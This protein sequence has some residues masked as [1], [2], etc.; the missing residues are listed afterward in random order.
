MVICFLHY[1]DRDMVI[2]ETRSLAEVWV[3]C[4]KVMFF[5]EYT[6][7]VQRQRNS[8]LSAN[9]RLQELGL[10]YYLLF[11]A[12][13]CVVAA[14]TMHFFATPEE[15]WHWIENPD[16]RTAHLMRPKQ[17]ESSSVWENRGGR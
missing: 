2:K 17:L 3:D 1:C 14:G 9:Q 16:G 12:K 10:A 15:A 6:L 7:V 5:P 13:L 11:P 8:F 4:A